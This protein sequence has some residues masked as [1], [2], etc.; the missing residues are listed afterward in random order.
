MLTGSGENELSSFPEQFDG[1]DVGDENV[2]SLG[3]EN[4]RGDIDFR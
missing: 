1:A 2:P 4:L 3:R